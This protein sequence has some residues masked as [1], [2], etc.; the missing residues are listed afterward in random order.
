[1]KFIPEADLQTVDNLWKAASDGKFGYSI[2][3]ELWLRNRQRWDKFFQQICWVQGEQN[4]YRSVQATNCLPSEGI[5][6]SFR[7]FSRNQL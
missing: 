3:R 1:M 4:M 7:L 6:K 2:Q 5:Y